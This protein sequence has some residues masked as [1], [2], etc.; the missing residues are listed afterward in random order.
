MVVA[1]YL[2]P[3]DAGYAKRDHQGKVT[4]YVLLWK[5]KGISLGYFDDYWKD[6]HGPVCARLPGQFQYWQHHVEHDKSMRRPDIEGIDFSCTEEEEFDGI[7]ELTFKSDTDRQTWFKASG[8]LMDDE[9]NLFSKGIGYN[10][11]EGNS[12]T[13]VD[14]IE[15]GD[16][17]GT[18]DILKFHVMI[19]KAQSVSVEE[20]RK[21]LKET[22]APLISSS[23]YVTK[24]RLH[25]FDE[26]DNTRPDAPGVSH[27]EPPE[28]QY[29]AAYEIAFPN[30]LIKGLFFESEEYKTAIQTL[31]TY[32]SKFQFFLQRSIYTLVYDGEPTL[33]GK[34]S[35]YVAN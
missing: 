19:R 23:K 17:N 16:H 28:K 4:F 15:V 35:P 3:V 21:Y 22:Y 24:F 32:V 2:N 5:K 25:L 18:S 26:V 27:F 14:R 6:V 33:A 10:T 7:A 29:Q 30:A 12:I 9:Y 1:D 31:P 8:I 20:F 34:R 11:S 13:Y